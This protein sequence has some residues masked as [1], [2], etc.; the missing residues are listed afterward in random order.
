M[1]LFYRLMLGA[2]AC[3]WTADLPAQAPEAAA[4][5]R[6]GNA[7]VGGLAARIEKNS[8][9]R[10]EFH[11]RDLPV[12]E[13]FGQLRQLVRKNIVVAP[14]VDERFT[15][16]IYD[17][18]VSEIIEVVC[19]STGLL[20]STEGSFIF[21]G[22]ATVAT[23]VFRLSY[24]R[25]Q[26]VL[27]I[28][29]PLGSREGKVTATLASE[30][31]IKTDQTKAGGDD[32]AESE[33][34]VVQDYPAY[35]ERIA[36]VIQ[37]LDIQ[38]RQV[39]IEARILSVTLTDDTAIG[40]DITKLAGIDFRSLS[41]VSEGGTNIT[42]GSLPGDQLDHFTG[43]GITDVAR[44]VPTGGLSVGIIKNDVG[45]FLRALQQVTDATVLANPKILA[46]NK[47]RGE[48]IVGRRDGYRTTTVTQTASI[49]NVE[50]LETGTRLVL[51]PF[52]GKD[53]FIRLE[54]HPEDSTGGVT[55]DGLPFK[56]TA[57]VTT[58]ILLKSGSTAVI[59][60][61]FRE[62]TTE[63]RSQVPFLGSLPW[64]GGLF[65]VKRDIVNREEIIILLTPR[66]VTPEDVVTPTEG[67]ADETMQGPLFT[68]R[69][70]IAQRY[71]VSA[72][73]LTTAGNYA[74]ASALLRAAGNLQ[75]ALEPSDEVER[76][77]YGALF[78]RHLLQSVDAIIL[79]QT[80]DKASAPGDSKP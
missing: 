75:P 38:P 32:Y 37:S 63:S 11:A 43:V 7:E 41:S 17:L 19:R 60:G 74:G 44:Q 58:N 49:E 18:T 77:V 50:F 62:R 39:L 57:E 5:S 8:S 16:D 10:F 25:A 4:E 59:G 65:R 40:V 21:V 52:V 67:G 26:D 30:T 28:V 80:R 68:T 70:R 9:G 45:G 72:E 1:R 61:L 36:H 27:P 3:L 15:G 31:G 33:I 55:T 42:P 66:I 12:S 35:I 24:V 14:G 46:L 78:P 34:L 73:T 20:A 64:I 79:E 29:E 71:L 47:Q 2:V 76:R 51:R 6:E 53:D 13:V 69:S 22:P 23:E 54:I 48:V 56:Q